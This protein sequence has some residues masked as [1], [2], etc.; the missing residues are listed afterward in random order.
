MQHTDTI[1]R[2]KETAVKNTQI[3]TAVQQ[4]TLLQPTPDNSEQC[5]Y[6]GTKKVVKTT[7]HKYVQKQ[8]IDSIQNGDKGTFLKVLQ[9]IDLLNVIPTDTKGSKVCYI[10]EKMCWCQFQS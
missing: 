3:K 4:N 5:C 2:K 7:V 10:N 8:I 1:T 9:T 6:F